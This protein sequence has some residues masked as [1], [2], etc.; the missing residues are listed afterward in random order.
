ML[1]CARS[2][3]IGCA[4]SGAQHDL[5][6]SPAGSGT[7]QARPIRPLPLPT[8]A[9]PHWPRVSTV[10]SSCKRKSALQI[11]PFH[12]GRARGHPSDLRRRHACT[13]LLESKPSIQGPLVR[14]NAATMRGRRSDQ[15][16]PTKGH[17]WLR[18]LAA[19]VPAA[20]PGKLWLRAPY[21]VAISIG[22]LR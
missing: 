5:D 18:M 3:T 1:G 21:G 16:L 19:Q 11:A 9:S 15:R 14:T 4:R 8:Q 17:S 20:T 10:G 2:E 22:Q 13:Q 12:Q 6:P 7:Q